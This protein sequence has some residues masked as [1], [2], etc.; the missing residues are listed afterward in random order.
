MGRKPGQLPE[1]P[2]QPISTRMRRPPTQPQCDF[3]YLRP[4]D[5]EL[6][7]RVAA[8]ASLKTKQYCILLM[9]LNGWIPSQRA[10]AT[11]QVIFPLG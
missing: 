5:A 9:A 11:T 1:S 2:I 8:N 7:L 6:R 3:L 4:Q 10:E